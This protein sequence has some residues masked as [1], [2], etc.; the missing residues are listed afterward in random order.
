[1]ARTPS[2]RVQALWCDRIH[3][4]ESSGL[5]IEQFCA[6]EGAAKCRSGVRASKLCD[7]GYKRLSIVR[8]LGTA[9]CAPCLLESF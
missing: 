4:E 1:M 7:H 3:R 8:Q 2:P 9:R 6:Q 5:T